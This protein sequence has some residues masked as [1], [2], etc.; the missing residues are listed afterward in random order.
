MPLVPNYERSLKRIRRSVGLLRTYGIPTGARIAL[1]N[2]KR[3]G[4]GGNEYDRRVR[5]NGETSQG[6]SRNPADAKLRSLK[7]PTF[8]IV[9]ET[10]DQADEAVRAAVA[11]VQRQLY[12]RWRLLAVET[13]PTS[14]LRRML[15]VRRH[16]HPKM[17]YVLEGDLAESFSLGREPSE[18]W[19]V[20]L[21][22]N[23]VLDPNTLLSIVETLNDDPDHDIIY[24]DHDRIDAI[25]LRS[26]PYFKPDFSIEHFLADQD[27]GHTVVLRKSLVDPV[28]LVEGIAKRCMVRHAT[29]RALSRS[30]LQRVLH[31]PGILHHIRTD[32]GP[33]TRP[34]DAEAG[35]G[36]VENY[37][38][39]AA[40]QVGRG[41]TV[42]RH[43][44]GGQWLDV[45]WPVPTPAPLV[46]VVIPTR[47]GA[48]LVERCVSGVLAGTRYANIEI[49]LVDNGSTDPRALDLFDRLQRDDRVRVQGNPIPFNYSKLNNDAVRLARGEMVLFLNNDIEVIG[50]EWLDIMVS[51]LARPG[52]GAVGAKLLYGDGR[53]QHAGVRLGAG[54]MEG[55]PGV[56]GHLGLLRDRDDSGYHGLYALTRQV[57]AATGACLLVRRGVFDE[58]GGFDEAL[59]VAYNDVDLCLRI[60]TAG[61]RIIQAQD[62]VL[63]HHESVSRGSDERPENRERF[64]AEARRMR[65]RWGQALLNDPFY[66]PNFDYRAAAD[67]TL[68]M[69]RI[70]GGDG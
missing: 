64:R 35:I 2:W 58:V 17:S 18:A 40:D 34:R 21:G 39:V 69:D 25:G 9:L 51:H 8:T 65:D 30:A 57:S 24:G 3:L 43:P 50:N 7:Q 14:P 31:V 20:L 46:S 41:G 67:F 66:N 55:H 48:D 38:A 36:A 15:K 61:W 13:R 60:G 53:V 28:D 33:P 5:R 37:V 16:L 26:N 49:I 27:V 4:Q 62:A 54:V 47:D 56:A 12:R 23:A 10:S 32:E 63:F 59:K 1:A 44:A 6:S 70:R 45:S 42:R 22:R 29:L 52:V 68:D 19:V 11:S